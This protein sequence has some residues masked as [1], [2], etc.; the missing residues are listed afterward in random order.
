MKP[1]TTAGHLS[2]IWRPE[3]KEKRL[4][5]CLNNGHRRESGEIV[6]FLAAIDA[7]CWR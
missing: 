1:L 5:H 4:L 3:F 6:L 2:S 7:S